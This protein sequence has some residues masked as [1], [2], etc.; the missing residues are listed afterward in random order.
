MPIHKGGGRE[1]DS[2]FGQLSF[3]G[4]MLC[5]RSFTICIV[6]DFVGKSRLEVSNFGILLFVDVI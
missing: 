1:T 5:D 3:F 2:G 6:R 4:S